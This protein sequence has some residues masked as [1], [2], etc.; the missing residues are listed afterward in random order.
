MPKSQRPLIILLEQVPNVLHVDDGRAQKLLLRKARQLGYEA[1]QQ[2]VD[3]NE[4]GSASRRVRL[5][6]TLV[7]KDVVAAV[8]FPDPP[9]RPTGRRRVMRDVIKPLQTRPAEHMLSR[10]GWTGTAA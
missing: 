10:A 4:F 9:A 3:S 5:F 1:R 6:T 2:I 8:G 7:R